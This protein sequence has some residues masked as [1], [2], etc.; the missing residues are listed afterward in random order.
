MRQRIAN[1]LTIT[2]DYVDFTT[3]TDIEVW[4]KQDAL[5]FTYTP[6][7]VSAHVMTIVV[8]FADAK[9][10]AEGGAEIQWAL[11][12]SNGLPVSP[13]PEI[14]TVGRLIKETGYDPV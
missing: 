1:K 7:V 2:C 11:V 8:P 14:I 12:D 9:Q 10:L 13:D 5:F 4:I 3:S 6:T